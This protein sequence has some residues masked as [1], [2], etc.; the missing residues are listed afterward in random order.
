MYFTYDYLHSIE[1]Y[2]IT[3]FG[4][5]P[6][7]YELELEMPQNYLK[8]RYQIHIFHYFIGNLIKI[9]IFY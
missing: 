3:N 8:Y 4:S 5:Q 2:I 6:G 9:E 1:K 7:C